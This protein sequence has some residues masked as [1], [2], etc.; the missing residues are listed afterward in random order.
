M[1]EYKCPY[2]KDGVRSACHILKIKCDYEPRF[3]LCYE[4][5]KAKREE[6]KKHTYQKEGE[7]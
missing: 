7:A 3:F 5:N 1:D 6:E 4:Y 2:S